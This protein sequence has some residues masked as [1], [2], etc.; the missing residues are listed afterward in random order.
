MVFLRVFR[1]NRCT[2]IVLKLKNHLKMEIM[3]NSD[4]EF[5]QCNDGEPLASME[6][7]VSVATRSQVVIFLLCCALLF[8]LQD[9]IFFALTGCE[10][11]FVEKSSL[12]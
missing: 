1:Y 10:N 4:M 2:T 7:V 3:R 5:H 8:R 9:P 6:D 11:S 12:F